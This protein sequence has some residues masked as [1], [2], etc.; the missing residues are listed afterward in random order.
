M[1]LVFV[2]R[3]NLQLALTKATVL[4]GIFLVFIVVLKIL[5]LVIIIVGQVQSLFT[6]LQ[7]NDIKYDVLRRNYNYMIYLLIYC[8]F[9]AIIGAVVCRGCAISPRRPL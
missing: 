5:F 2:C 9:S 6:S 8:R 4:V 3:Y 1:Q 7:L